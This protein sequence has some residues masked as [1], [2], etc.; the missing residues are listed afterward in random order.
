VRRSFILMLIAVCALAPSA[1]AAP[2]SSW[3][4]VGPQWAS[5]NTCDPGSRTV[6]VRASQAGDSEGRRMFTRFSYQWLSAK[7]GAWQSI[8]GAGSGWLAAGPGLWVAS[9]TGWN[10]AFLPAPAG[11]TFKI[12]GVVEMQWREGGGVKRSATLLTPQV[13]QLR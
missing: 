1:Q 13:C 10:Q 5:V 9:E 6:G 2:G 7:T 3:E 4:A 8:A 11:S 12:R